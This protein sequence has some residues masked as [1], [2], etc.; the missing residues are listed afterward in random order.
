M[1]SPAT[2]AALEY[3][4]VGFI[5]AGVIFSLGAWLLP[6]APDDEGDQ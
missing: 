4:I 1:N 2:H 5:L 6:G 3:L